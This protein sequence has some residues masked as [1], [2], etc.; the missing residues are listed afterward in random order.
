M[1]STKPNGDGTPRIT[2][3]PGSNV[4]Y[5]PDFLANPHNYFIPFIQDHYEDNDAQET[6]ARDST[7]NRNSA[8]QAGSTR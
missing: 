1:R 4:N 6:A 7:W 2:L 5:A 8:R 3:L